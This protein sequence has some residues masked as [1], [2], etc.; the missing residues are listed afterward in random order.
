LSLSRLITILGKLLVVSAL[1]WSMGRVVMEKPPFDLAVLVLAAAGM[2]VSTAL[3][4]GGLG[5]RPLG[6]LLVMVSVGASVIFLVD[7][8]VGDGKSK[9]IWSL[10][11]LSTHLVCLGCWAWSARPHLGTRRGASVGL[12]AFISG[13]WG[14]AMVLF[15]ITGSLTSAWTFV[16]TFVLGIG[17]Y[18]LLVVALIALPAGELTHIRDR[19][20]VAL[21]RPWD[22]IP[23]TLLG[24]ALALLGWE[25][26]RNYGLAVSDYVLLAVGLFSMLW[27][28]VNILAVSI[29]VAVAWRQL[30]AERTRFKG[31]MDTETD[32]ETGFRIPRLRYLPL[33]QISV[34]WDEPSAVDVTLEKDGTGYR[35]IVRAHTRGNRHHI[36]RAIEVSDLFGLATMTVRHREAMTLQIAPM[37]G[38]WRFSPI[39]R[40][41]TGEGFSHPSGEKVGERI[42]MRRYAHGDSLRY[43]IWK[44]FARSRRLL[45]RTPERALSPQPSTVAFLVAGHGDDAAAGT[46][47]RFVEDALGGDDSVFA[48]DGSVEPSQ[49]PKEAVAQIISS[50]EHREK[51]GSTLD[52]F[53]NHVD[54]HQLGSC[55]IFAPNQ[56]G[57]WI[58][59]VARFSKSLPAP[60]TVVLSADVTASTAPKSRLQHFLF[61]ADDGKAVTHANFFRLYDTLLEAGL[62]V[63]VVHAVTG[64]SLMEQH[65]TALRAPGVPS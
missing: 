12:L 60:A 26:Y 61:G 52:Q 54:R 2:L 3:P 43:I 25:L 21:R 4:A 1:G 65:L 22:R 64:E 34:T 31:V 32:V 18:T 33:V 55:V 39:M 24:F 17:A 13:V 38:N 15:S 5:W 50:V 62:R 28:G 56:P 58:D 36:V 57:A 10:L 49:D 8:F 7:A 47:R 20:A 35:E 9:G 45:V 11:G 44:A 40:N 37:R 14:A 59:H 46:A 30:S 16:P 51:G 23:F 53:L 63:E 29:G 6:R 27:V 19:W 48:A 42:D 41:V